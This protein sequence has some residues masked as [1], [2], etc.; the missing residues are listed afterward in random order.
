MAVKVKDA[1]A[2]ATKF[3]TRA[4]GA[5]QDY[6]TGVANSGNTWMQ[7]TAAAAPTWA[8]GVQQAVSNGQFSKG[9]SQAAQ[10]KLINRVAQ[11]GSSRF[12]TGVAQ[13]GPAWQA[14]TAPYLQTIANLTL[15]PRGPKGAPQNSQR[16]Q[17]ITDALRAKK[18]GTS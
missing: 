8:A 6:A 1:A 5:A 14:G 7:N 11:V 3:Q 13:A 12:S 16:V 17:A 2:A 15:P 4:S 9:I 10:A 18:L